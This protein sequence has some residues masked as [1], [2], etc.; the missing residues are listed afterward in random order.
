MADLSAPNKHPLVRQLGLQ[1]VLERDTAASAVPPTMELSGD[2]L[3]SALAGHV[4]L[5]WQRGKLTKWRMET[6]LLK[7]LRARRGEY[8]A[9]EIAAMQDTG[10]INIIWAPLTETKCRA[11]SAW[12]REIVLPVGEQPWGVDPQ[13]K[14]DLPTPLK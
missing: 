2:L 8:S 9:S 10:V 6:E 11:A 1:Q 3:E 4:R 5:A 7:C 12:I 13:P 14:P